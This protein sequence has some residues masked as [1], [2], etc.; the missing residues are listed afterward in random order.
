[1]VPVT[2]MLFCI[3]YCSMAPAQEAALPSIGPV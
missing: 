1:M 2:G 3:W